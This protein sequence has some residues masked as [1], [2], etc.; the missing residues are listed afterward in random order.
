MISSWDRKCRLCCC[1]F[2]NNTFLYNNTYRRTFTY[3]K[4]SSDYQRIQVLEASCESARGQRGSH[5]GRKLRF[6][7][8]TVARRSA[9]LAGRRKPNLVNGLDALMENGEMQVDFDDYR[10]HGLMGPH[11][12]ALIFDGDLKWHGS[13]ADSPLH[14][15]KI[16][17]L[18]R[19]I[20]EMTEA[21]YDLIDILIA[22]NKKTLF[23]RTLLHRS[24]YDY[25]SSFGQL[26]HR[27]F[28]VGYE[29]ELVQS[30]RIFRWSWKVSMLH[31]HSHC[32]TIFYTYLHRN[33]AHPILIDI[34]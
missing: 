17:Y 18:L 14:R 32:S 5:C 3:R 7:L 12:R 20:G 26:Q 13:N 30:W 31:I 8:S 29:A 2:L 25:F 24:A 23:C 34:I 22:A 16:T 28:H 15:A 10:R 9:R 4:S 21:H 27:I 1:Y 33:I 19:V 6:C 11:V